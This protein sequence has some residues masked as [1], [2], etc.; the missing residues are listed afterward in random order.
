MWWEKLLNY[1]IVF[2]SGGFFCL[3][4]QILIIKT[5]LTP[6]RILV[7]FLLGT[8]QLRQQLHQVPIVRHMQA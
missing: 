8:A 5:K 6:A 1:L 3:L 2:G 4:A 7:I